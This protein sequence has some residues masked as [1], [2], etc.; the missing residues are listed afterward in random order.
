M[1]TRIVIL[2]AGESGVGSAILAQQKGFDVFVS[3]F[4][5]IKQRYVEELQRFNISFE[6]AK[7]SDDLILNASEIIKSPGIP[8]K[9]PIIQKIKQK[10]ISIISEIEF[11][12]RYATGTKIGITGSNGKTTTTS[13]IF[14]IL[15]NEGLN[16]A[17]C[18]NIGHSFA[19]AVA[20]KQYDC[21]VIELS[22]FQ[23]DDIQNFKPEIAVLLNITPDHL[24]RYGYEFQNYIDSKFRIAKNLGQNDVL[25]FGADDP[26]VA[27][28]LGKR[29]ITAQC[30]PFGEA[31]SVKNQHNYAH[32]N[33]KEIIIKYKTEEFMLK[34]EELT[35]KGRHNVAN[36]M[37]ASI[38]AKAMNIRK[39]NIRESMQNF[40]NVPHRLEKVG[41]YKGV[42]FINDSKAT[43][44]N[45]VWYALE[46]MENATVWI[47]GGVDKGNDYG[48]LRNLV[49]QKVRAIVCLG[50]DNF[51]IIQ[52]F[53]S[54]GRPIEEARSMKEAVE[55]SLL[56]AKEA[57]TVL[58]SPACASFDLFENYEDR[59]DQFRKIVNDLI[60]R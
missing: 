14:H 44:V 52:E 16:V 31:E 25:V 7:H 27:E 5:T 28:E 24:D 60:M 1:K 8:D 38:V 43:N 23:L 4:G 53:Q 54:L 2:G 13:L 50:T 12:S 42:E 20:E 58:L 56:H 19:R 59:G 55:K 32:Y 35:I 6:A 34:L 49:S 33:G 57:D 18:G 41:N 29:K 3:D 51:K 9:A 26:V 45:S 15:K 47:V 48:Q 36:S 30:V 40:K 21:Y 37:A 22:S 46:S 10:G 17:L 39:E 11:A